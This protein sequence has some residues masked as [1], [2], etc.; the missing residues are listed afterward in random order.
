MQLKL[1]H[2]LKL[3]ARP[4]KLAKLKNYMNYHLSAKLRPCDFNWK[5]RRLGKSTWL[6]DGVKHPKT[7]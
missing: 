1:N 2:V 5:R 3:N 6:L 4:K 7:I